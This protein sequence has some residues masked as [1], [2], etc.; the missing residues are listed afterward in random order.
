VFK[1]EFKAE[2]KAELGVEFR[3]EFRQAVAAGKSESPAEFREARADTKPELRIREDPDD[4]AE[5]R[6]TYRQIMREG[7]AELLRV[8]NTGRE[9]HLREAAR[10]EAELLIR[11]SAAS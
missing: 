11:P 8:L 1:S 2:L 3:A 9:E 10:I 7:W 4:R 6:A 5:I